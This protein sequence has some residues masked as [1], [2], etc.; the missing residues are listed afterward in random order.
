MASVDINS[1]SCCIF[2]RVNVERNKSGVIDVKV[3]ILVCEL[4]FTEKVTILG[5]FCVCAVR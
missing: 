5:L 2:G 4:G 3:L 1:H